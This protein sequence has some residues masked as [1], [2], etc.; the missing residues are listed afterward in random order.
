MKSFLIILLS[1][2][3]FSCAS[4][5]EQANHLEFMMYSDAHPELNDAE[6]SLWFGYSFGLG[7]CIQNEN[8]SYDRYPMKCEVSARKAMAQMYENETDKSKYSNSY[9][10][11][12]FSVYRAGFMEAYVWSNNQ[13]KDW[14]R[15]KNTDE[16]QTWAI[17]NLKSHI[18][19]Q[20]FMGKFQ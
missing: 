18:P 10:K 13:Q 12:L 4:T 14:K 17:S 11:E 2:F 7:I 15:P 9:P 8:A 3:L 5:K 6:S 19:Q 16:F 20:K 1:V